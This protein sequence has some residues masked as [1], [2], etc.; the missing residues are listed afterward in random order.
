MKLT[1]SSGA[2]RAAAFAAVLSIAPLNIAL[3]SHAVSRLGGFGATECITEACER[4]V[5]NTPQELE[6][7]PFIEELKRRTA[8]NSA[9]N[10]ATVKERTLA[11]STG[12]INDAVP[13]FY[14]SVRYDGVT[15]ILNS[16]QVKA[17][18]AEG[19]ELDCPTQPG[20]PCVVRERQAQ[21]AASAPSGDALP[22]D[23]PMLD[24]DAISSGP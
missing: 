19:F 24:P 4:R 14:T 7:S 3:P 20:F 2:A 23:A 12:I 16:E 5:A 6:T 13:G 21:V 22:A 11:S 15:R 9:K 18:Q 17:L 10:A 1:T 8:D